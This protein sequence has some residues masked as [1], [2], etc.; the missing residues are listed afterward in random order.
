MAFDRKTRFKSRAALE[1]STAL[2]VVTAAVQDE[3]GRHAADLAEE[4]V[5][6]PPE[7]P[8]AAPVRRAGRKAAAPVTAPADLATMVA[9]G[10]LPDIPAAA[11]T[12][13][14]AALDPP[15]QRE[16]DPP[17]VPAEALP[18]IPDVVTEAADAIA[19][20]GLI[21]ADA[22]ETLVEPA[23]SAVVQIRA[24][25]VEAA[26]TVAIEARA[27]VEAL[28][29]LQAKMA[30]AMRVTFEDSMSFVTALLAVRSLPEA[31]SLNSE[32]LSRRVQTLTAQGCE[33]TLLAQKVAMDA[34]RTASIG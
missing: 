20:A 8:P 27:G 31:M 18:P 21:T 28:S 6:A 23:R 10:P 5:A 24:E 13:G 7:L 4:A 30:D 16:A 14:D 33:L 2:P 1:G 15:L 11:A 26:A 9:A 29:A 17:P 22:V 32:H 19:D 25:T 3:A 12:S 34:W